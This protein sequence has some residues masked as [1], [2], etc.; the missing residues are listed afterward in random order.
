MCRGILDVEIDYNNNNMAFT[1][2]IIYIRSYNNRRIYFNALQDNS[3]Y[4]DVVGDKN[5][6][7]IYSLVDGIQYQSI[8]SEAFYVNKLSEYESTGEAQLQVL[9]SLID[10]MITDTEEVYTIHGFSFN[11][12]T[13]YV[14]YKTTNYVKIT[15]TLDGVKVKEGTVRF[16]PNSIIDI[17]NKGEELANE[18]KNMLN[19]CPADFSETYSPD[20][21]HFSF[22][23]GGKYTKEAGDR[24]VY[25]YNVLDGEILDD[26]VV[27]VNFNINKINTI[28]AD[29]TW[30]KSQLDQCPTNYTEDYHITRE[31]NKVNCHFYIT[32]EYSKLAGSKE[33]RTTILLDNDIYGNIDVRDFNVYYPTEAEDYA[34]LAVGDLKDKLDTII[35]NDINTVY[36]KYGFDFNIEVYF[37]KAAGDKDVSVS[38]KIEKR[39]QLDYGDLSEIETID[40]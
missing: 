35:L 2:D 9:K 27:T 6:V 15:V 32:R 22:F 39:K 31:N 3:K 37:T 28:R 16:N 17:K 29:L 25:I 34:N 13:Y 7:Y 14:K 21:S 1:L 38:Y 4:I 33:V 5:K 26:K 23:I 12:N 18:V 11:I 36:K 10:S 19:T 20:E 30:L 40:I 8:I 24:R